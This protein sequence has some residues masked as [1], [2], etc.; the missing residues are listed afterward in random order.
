MIVRGSLDST[1]GDYD[2][3]MSNRFVLC[4]TESREFLLTIYK[5]ELQESI[6][7]Y[8][9][10]LVR[11]TY[12]TEFMKV[13]ASMILLFLTMIPLHSEDNSRQKAFLCN[14]LRLYK[15]YFVC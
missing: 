10:T 13:I 7:Q 1:I 14:A 9:E 6:S 15:K 2:L 4:E 8:S 3:I 12:P 11:A 5:T